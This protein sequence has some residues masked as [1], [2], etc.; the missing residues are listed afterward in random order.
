MTI[1]QF[2][3]DT[4]AV[5][6]YLRE[7]FH[8]DQIYILGHSWGSLIAL[9]AAARSPE[10]F[11]AYLG[12]AQM[13]HQLESE[14]VAYDHMLAAYRERG[15]LKMIR[16][17]EA[18]PVTMTGGTP[19]RYLRLRD[20]AMHRLGVGTTHD[21]TSVITGIFL[22]S[23]RFRGYTLREKINLWRG[24]AFSR[25]LGLWNQ[26]LTIDLRKTV[27]ALQIPA[28]FFVGRFDY[29]CVTSLAKDYYDQLQAPVKGLYVFDYSA[30]SPLLEE[31]QK[32]HRILEHDVLGGAT[33]LADQR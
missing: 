11:K 2:I 19:E 13:V 28:Y 14:K 6:D 21:M 3:S 31:P 10:R 17:L 5:T 20:T 4:L 18:A 15:D 30:H 26:F 33:T 9:R 1:E 32:A 16:E 24:R 25:S 7:R 29:T 8:Q 27:P 22:A 12:M 23:W